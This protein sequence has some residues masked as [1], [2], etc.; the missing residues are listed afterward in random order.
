MILARGTDS[1]QDSFLE[2]IPAFSG[3]PVSAPLRKRAAPPPGSH[4]ARGPRPA[5]SLLGPRGPRP[6]SSILS[7]IS[8]SPYVCA[9]R[10]GPSLRPPIFGCD[11]L[12]GGRVL[13]PGHYPPGPHPGGTGGTWFSPGKRRVGSVQMDDGAGRGPMLSLSRMR[14]RCS[15]PIPILLRPSRGKKV[16]SVEASPPTHCVSLV[17]C[18]RRPG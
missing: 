12:R 1:L 13:P 4:P 14:S 10:S 8:A 18:D 6:D 2:L 17:P 5:A 9:G 3:R 11:H 15:T 16:S 7:S